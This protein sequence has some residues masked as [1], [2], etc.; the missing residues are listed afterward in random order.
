MSVLIIST[1][2]ALHCTS[3]VGFRDDDD[4]EDY[5]LMWN[6]RSLVKR[7][8]SDDFARYSLDDFNLLKMIGK[9]SFGKVCMKRV[10]YIRL[11]LTCHQTAQIVSE[12]SCV[13]QLRL[14]IVMF[15][16]RIAFIC[17]CL[18][19]QMGIYN[20]WGSS[21]SVTIFANVLSALF[22][23]SSPTRVIR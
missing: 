11:Q 4:D 15:L 21:R 10:A 23:V 20:L 16:F 9:G 13:S 1:S 5:E 17:Y 12:L 6:K 7:S 14:W 22:H 18:E 3:Q 19:C 2:H 8:G